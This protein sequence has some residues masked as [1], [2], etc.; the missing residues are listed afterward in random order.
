MARRGRPRAKPLRR[1]RGEG[2][3]Y[4]DADRDR[5]I[6]EITVNGRR[7]RVTGRTQAEAAARLR[8]LD[9]TPRRQG[10]Y[11]VGELAQ[12]W[13]EAYQRTGTR[14]PT[15]LSVRLERVRRHIIDD[16]EIAGIP[17][18]ELE[19]RDVERWLARKISAGYVD[20]AG[21]HREYAR[22]T[23][24]SIRGDL[25]QILTWAV[26][27][28]QLDW[29]PATVAEVERPPKPPPKR[30]LTAEQARALVAACRT[31]EPRW[32]V[33]A[34]TCLLLGLRPGEA[35]ALRE[36]RIDWTAGTVRIDTAMKRSSGGRPLELGPVK[37][38]RSRT[39]EAPA[40]LLAALR[41]IHLQNVEH[42]LLLGP[43]WPKQ[44]DGLL[45]VRDD[46]TPPYGGTLRKALRRIC[47]AA[48]LDVDDLTIYE[49]RHT[50]ASLLDAAGVPVRDIVDA[51]GH[52]DDRMFYRHYRH[53]PD[54]VVRTPAA[55]ERIVGG[56]QV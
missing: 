26:K 52:V 20:A 31:E 7:R 30:T 51:L 27:R 21:R 47:A 12:E 22:S 14:G 43:A 32:G 33:Y 17:T 36:N 40:D 16:P 45:F 3:V 2:S 8:Q 19:A 50:F 28:R 25:S 10:R 53:R 46:G 5:W 18:D 39:V 23:I 42:R 24:D 37:T 48:D 44:W 54:P 49:L 55:W 34:L 6:G 15:T 41:T 4:Y 29:N 9:D 35:A 13:S 11:T 1:A 38:S 56:D